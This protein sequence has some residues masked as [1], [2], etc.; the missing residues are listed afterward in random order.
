VLVSE[1]LLKQCQVPAELELEDMGAR[2]LRG[3][4]EALR[5]YSMRARG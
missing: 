3:K 2:E 4:D 1:A 5:L